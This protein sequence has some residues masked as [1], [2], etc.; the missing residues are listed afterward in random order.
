MVLSVDLGQSGTRIRMGNHNITSPRGKLSGEDPLTALRTVFESIEKLSADTVALSCTGFN[1]VVPEPGDYL[2]LC[3]EFFSAKKVVLIDDGLAGYF[4]ALQGVNGVVLTIGGGVVSVGGN[5]GVF[6]HRDGLGSTFGDEGGGFWLGKLAITRA[7]AFRQGRGVDDGLLEVF[8]KQVAA[9]DELEIKNAAD[10]A[11]LAITSAKLLLDA[12]DAKI[13]SAI[14]IRD[15]GAQLLA[16]TV[17]ATWVGAKGSLIQSPQIAIQGG[18]S[19]NRNYVLAIQSR[20][21]ETLP[22]AKFVEALGDNLDGATWI[23][24]NMLNDLPPLLRWAHA[25]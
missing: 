14:K 10:A 16:D 2:A 25:I 19:S 15:D 7:L 18:P 23:G 8:Q 1:G 22:S 5:D 9:Y 13:P 3:M 21:A 11:T 12:A 20:I 4:G 17:V 6:A 24:E